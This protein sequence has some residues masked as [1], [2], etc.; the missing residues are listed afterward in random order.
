MQGMQGM[1]GVLGRIAA[2]ESRIDAL[3]ESPAPVSVGGAPDSTQ[4]EPVSFA[5]ALQATSALATSQ[6]SQVDGTVREA[7]AKYG[8]DPALVRAVIRT[9][10]DYDPRCRSSAGAMGLMQL[11]P[12]TCHDYGISDPYDITQNIDGGC[13][14]LSGYFKQFGGNPELALAAYNA[15]AGAVRKYGGIP[16]YRETQ[17]Y[18]PKVMGLWRGGK[19]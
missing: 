14:E 8:L 18:V 10:S 17:A 16:P 11:M 1:Q 12:E 6:N 15:G 9:E 5:Q 13:R 19:G 7:A 3:Q 4:A 2:I